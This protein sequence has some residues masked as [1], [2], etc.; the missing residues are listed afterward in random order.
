MARYIDADVLLR[1]IDKMFANS[2][3]INHEKEMLDEIRYAETVDA[4]PVIRCPQCGHSLDDRG[5][6][7]CDL[8][9]QYRGAED[10][11]SSGVAREAI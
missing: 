6:L 1:D 7:Y 5:M 11:C 10:Y 9:R 3:C 4:I 2:G 8:F